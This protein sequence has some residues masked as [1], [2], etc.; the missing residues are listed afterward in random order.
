MTNTREITDSLGELH[1]EID[2]GDGSFTCTP[3]SAYDEQQA[4][5]KAD[6]SKP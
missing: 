4:A 1:I 6:D 2:N 5:L 3:K